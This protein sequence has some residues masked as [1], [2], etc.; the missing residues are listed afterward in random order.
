M[1][2]NTWIVLGTMALLGVTA[3]TAEAEATQRNVFRLRMEVI[4]R[5]QSADPVSGEPRIERLV[6]TGA[7]LVKLAL[8]KPLESDPEPGKV[9]AFVHACGHAKGHIV[10][11]D[12][13]SN[14]VVAVIATIDAE[15]NGV[16][17]ELH[18]INQGLFVADMVFGTSGTSENGITKGDHKIAGNY[19]KL[20]EHCPFDIDAHGVGTLDIVEDGEPYHLLAMETF[21]LT[22]RRLAV[23]PEEPAD[24]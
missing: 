14:S 17:S 23:L 8:G 4:A 13:T 11:F 24:E 7:D 2:I 18:A 10:V 12:R 3:T 6:L 22:G 1:K 20:P 21:L 5:Y 16:I 19:S 9:L 15:K